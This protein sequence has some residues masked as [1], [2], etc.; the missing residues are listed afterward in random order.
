MGSRGR[1]PGEHT[2][3]RRKGVVQEEEE[4]GAGK[5]QAAGLKPRGAA[6]SG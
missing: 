2:G 4:Q 5:L 6:R 3:V 1:L